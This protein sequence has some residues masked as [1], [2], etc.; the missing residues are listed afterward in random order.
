MSLMSALFKA[1]T[2]MIVNSVMGLVIAKTVDIV[3]CV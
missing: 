1:D 3:I 2:V